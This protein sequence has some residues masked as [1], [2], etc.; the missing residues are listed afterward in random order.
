MEVNAIKTNTQS[1]ETSIQQLK[2]LRA[3]CEAKAMN[4]TVLSGGGESIAVLRAIDEEFNY[5]RNRIAELIGNAAALLENAKNAMEE[6]DQQSAAAMNGGGDAGN[7]ALQGPVNN[8]V[9]EVV[10]KQ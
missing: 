6:A 2:D 8:R 1:L 5:I 4:T 3:T 10:M 9:T 7:S